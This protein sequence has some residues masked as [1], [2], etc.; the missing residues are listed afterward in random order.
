MQPSRRAFL[1]GRSARQH[2]PATP[3]DAFCQR[4]THDCLGRVSHGAAMPAQS[5]RLAPLG[6]ADV[7]RACAL[8]GQYGVQLALIHGEIHTEKI[9]PGQPVLWLDPTVALARLEP[10]VDAPGQW[11]AEAGVRVADLLAA[12]LTQFADAPADMTL[13]HW[14]AGPASALCATGRTQDAGVVSLEVLLADGTYTTLGSFG[15]RATEP[16]R[17]AAVQRLIP[18]LFELSRGDDAAVCL[19]HPQWLPRVRLDALHSADVNLAHVLLGHGGSLAWVHAAVLTTPAARL[20]PQAAASTSPVP[21]ELRHT[22]DRLDAA[23]KSLFDPQ[24]I[25][26]IG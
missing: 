25:M 20:A 26:G 23:V 13:A 14:L 12:G 10:V 7:Q 16:L 17:G 9:A 15:E 8:C 24:H 21:P 6:V 4:L 5:A 22:A 19:A 3:W 11:R 1:L 2:A 18:Q